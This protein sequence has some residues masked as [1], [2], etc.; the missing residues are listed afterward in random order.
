[1]GTPGRVFEGFARRQ[2]GLFAND[3]RSADLFGMFQRV[4]D[5]P[6]TAEELYGFESL[7]SDP[8]GVLKDPFSLTRIL[9][10]MS[11]DHF[12]ANTLGNRFGHGRKFRLQIR[13]DEL[14]SA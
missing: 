11:R 4:G 12:H 10:G 3:A 2:G 5:D 8:D 13:H 14:P 1:Q 9:G 7:V 6:V